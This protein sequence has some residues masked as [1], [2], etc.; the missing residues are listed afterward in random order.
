MWNG[1]INSTSILNVSALAVFFFKGINSSQHTIVCVG[2]AACLLL[3]MQSLLSTSNA[4][5]AT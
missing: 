1:A 5:A 3:L 2:P 4:A